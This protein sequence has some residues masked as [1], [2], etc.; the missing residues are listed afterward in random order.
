ME[1]IEKEEKKDYA[2]KRKFAMIVAAHNE[3]VVIGKLVKSILGQN[4][5]KELFEV[6]VIA[7]NCDDNT[8]KVAKE[9]GAKVF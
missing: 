5:P 6:F 4:Y 2:P 3:E 8:S 9:A 7:D 1:L